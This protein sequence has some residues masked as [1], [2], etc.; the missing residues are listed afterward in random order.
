M[1]P[2]DDQIGV[3][4]RDP[5]SGK[6]GINDIVIQ[7]PRG[8]VGSFRVALQGVKAKAGEAKLG[9]HYVGAHM[10]QREIWV[11]EDVVA[12]A[13]TADLANPYYWFCDR[14]ESSKTHLAFQ[15]K[16]PTRALKVSVRTAEFVLLEVRVDS[17]ITLE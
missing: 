17:L 16:P 8:V 9:L 13:N 3:L 2:R 5:V 12:N 15:Q 6:R 14:K 4:W 11:M 1:D 10:N 7:V